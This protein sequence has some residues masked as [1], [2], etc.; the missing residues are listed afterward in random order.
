[1]GSELEGDFWLIKATATSFDVQQLAPSFPSA[2]L[3]LE[4]AAYIP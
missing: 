3:N 2:N 4:G 1:M